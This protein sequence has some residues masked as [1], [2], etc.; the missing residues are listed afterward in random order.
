M[1]QRRQPGRA[2]ADLSPLGVLDQRRRRLRIPGAQVAQPEQMEERS[3][4][5]PLAGQHRHLADVGRQPAQRQHAGPADDDGRRAG[6]DQLPDRPAAGAH[7]CDEPARHRQHTGR[8]GRQP[9]GRRA[10]WHGGP[11]RS[12]AADLRRLARQEAQRRQRADRQLVACRPEPDAALPRRGRLRHRGRAQEPGRLCRCLLG[13][14]RRH[15]RCRAQVQP[16]AAGD[17]GAAAAEEQAFRCP[18]AGTPAAG[19][20]QRAAAHRGPRRAGRGG[21][22]GQR[23]DGLAGRPGRSFEH[24]GRAGRQR[25][26]PHRQSAAAP[27]AHGGDAHAQPGAVAGAVDA[28]RAG[29]GCG[30]T[31]GRRLCRQPLP[32]RRHRR[33]EAVRRRQPQR[34]SH[35]SAQPRPAPAAGRSADQADRWPRPPRRRTLPKAPGWPCPRCAPA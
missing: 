16:D 4:H 21:L 20:G 35:R 9:G 2:A 19:H 12:Q 13:P 24:A 26:A 32:A 10:R 30:N 18:A 6:A 11:A 7:A 22:Q 5:R 29:D 31:E 14:G 25:A 1:E 15:P 28:I 17:R 3:D 33:H 23:R 8:S 34:R 27:P